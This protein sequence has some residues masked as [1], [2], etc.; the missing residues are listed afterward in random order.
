MEGFK[1]DQAK[2]KKQMV[3]GGIAGIAI[4]TLLFVIGYGV[5]RK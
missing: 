4:S 1:E 3:I 5:G 2:V